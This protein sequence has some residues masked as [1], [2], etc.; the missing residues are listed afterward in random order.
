MN[1]QNSN[2]NSSPTKEIHII[3]HTTSDGHAELSSIATD[4]ERGMSHRHY[5]QCAET[6]ISP[7]HCTFSGS[8]TQ[9]SDQN[10]NEF[11]VGSPV[12]G[13]NSRVFFSHHKSCSCRGSGVGCDCTKKCSC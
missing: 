3:A 6:G 8:S 1:L 2:M 9:S 13:D 4:N 10:E 5:T 11:T 7:I 12:Y